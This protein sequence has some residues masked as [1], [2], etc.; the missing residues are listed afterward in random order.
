MLVRRSLIL[1]LLLA[2]VSAFAQRTNRSRE[3]P[4]TGD[5]TDRDVAWKFLSKEVVATPSPVM[6]YWLPSTAKETETSRLLTS[7]RLYD[8]ATRCVTYFVVLPGD[9]ANAAKLAVTGE[10]AMI[11]PTN[12]QGK[13]TQTVPAVH[14]AIPV[15]NVERAVEDELN[16]RDEAMYG[17]MAEARTLAPRNKNAAIAL[18]RKIWDDRC[19]CPMAG[20]EAQ[21]ALKDLGVVVTEPAAAPLADP[22]LMEPGLPSK[23]SH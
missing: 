15:A 23:P 17:G 14:G 11:V 9:T 6:V 19:L 4:G 3:S 20:T 13:V 21:R 22:N 5:P 1:L 16:A 10:R 2:S 18:Y 8:A 7:R 12:S